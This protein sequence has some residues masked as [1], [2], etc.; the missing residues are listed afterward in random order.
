MCLDHSDEVN[1]KSFFYR[2]GIG[3]KC[4]GNRCEQAK[5]ICRMQGMQ[6]LMCE[7]AEMQKCKNA[8]MQKCKKCKNWVVLPPPN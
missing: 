8:K 6:S 1:I 5:L 2:L 3:A 7:N 4:E